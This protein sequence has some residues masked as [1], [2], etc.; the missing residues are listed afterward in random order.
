MPKTLKSGS[1]RYLHARVQ[2]NTIHNSQE[3]K[4]TQISVNCWMDKIY[5][6]IHPI[7]YYAALKKGNPVTC[8][9]QMY[10]VDCAKWNKPVAKRQILYDIIYMRYPKWLNLWKQKGGW[11]LSGAGERG[12]GKLSFNEYRV[13]VL[14]DEK[15]LEI[16]FTTMEI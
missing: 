4:A 16:C 1:Q 15:C 12:Q 14:W 7:E 2:S 3:V 8:H 6:H 9:N 11:C 5:I 13:S 10:L